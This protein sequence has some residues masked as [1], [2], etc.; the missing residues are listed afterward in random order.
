[1]AACMDYIM[2]QYHEIIEDTEKKNNIISAISGV[3]FFTGWWF[4]IDITARY[5]P[6]DFSNFYHICGI[7]G[8]ISFIIINSIS[9][10]NIEMYRYGIGSYAAWIWLFLGFVLGFGSLIASIWILFGAYILPGIN[11][12]PG[13]GV[14][15]QNLFIFIGSLIFKFGRK[16]DLM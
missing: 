10:K 15:A 9:T 14:F 6:A 1:M 7:L 3:F 4:I 11:I 12:I 16:E 2:N 5:G 13:L 8:T